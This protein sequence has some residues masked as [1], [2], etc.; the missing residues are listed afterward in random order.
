MMTGRIEQAFKD[1]ER[2]AQHKW[3]WGDNS[4]KKAVWKARS[5]GIFACEMIAERWRPSF[6]WRILHRMGVR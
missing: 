2:A 1:G 4:H 5:R 6:L 3:L